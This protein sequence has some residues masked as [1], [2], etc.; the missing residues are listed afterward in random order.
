M[1]TNISL[2]KLKKTTKNR[3]KNFIF[4]WCATGFLLLTWMWISS[5]LLKWQYLSNYYNAVSYIF[6]HILYK[7]LHKLHSFLS[8][9]C[10]VC[11]YKVSFRYNKP[12][13]KLFDVTSVLVCTIY[14]RI[15]IFIIIKERFIYK[16]DILFWFLSFT[17][18]MQ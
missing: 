12:S 2:R 16:H 18:R 9:N 13:W 1:L 11:K 14:I 10:K 5:P 7:K 3:N 17:K 4:L 15:F 8:K 6:L